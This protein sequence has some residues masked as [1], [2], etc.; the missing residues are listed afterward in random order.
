MPDYKKMYFA[1]FNAIT[2]AVDQLQSAQRDGENTYIGSEDS[3]LVVLPDQE[4]KK[5]EEDG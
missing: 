3:P 4:N 5:P 2:V 1:L